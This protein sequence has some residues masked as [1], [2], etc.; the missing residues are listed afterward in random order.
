MTQFLLHSAD[1]AGLVACGPGS[2]CL[3]A[4]WL[5]VGC[6]VMLSVGAGSVLPSVG[7][8]FRIGL[9][10]STSASLDT[11]GSRDCRRCLRFVP[12]NLPFSV[13]TA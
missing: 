3:L 11:N 7:G 2:A 5:G 1:D 4:C 13:L 10:I 6:P 12:N 8:Q 9:G